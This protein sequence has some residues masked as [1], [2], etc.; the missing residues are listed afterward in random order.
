M[1]G[2]YKRGIHTTDMLL[3]ALHDLGIP[4]FIDAEKLVS[5]LRGYDTENC[6][7]G[8]RL[9]TPTEKMKN[10]NG[11]LWPTSFKTWNMYILPKEFE[12]IKSEVD[13]VEGVDTLWD[14]QVMDYLISRQMYQGQSLAATHN[15]STA[16]TASTQKKET[17]TYKDDEI[18]VLPIEITDNELNELERLYSDD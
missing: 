4:K 9:N 10:R 16:S 11:Y 1:T 5:I 3:P 12:E 15:P 14:A 7:G 18:E 8:I 13:Y 2:Q 6:P 17:L